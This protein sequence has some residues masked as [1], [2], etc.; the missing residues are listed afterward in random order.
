MRI[1]VFDSGIGGTA[2]AA[3]LRELLPHTEIMTAD[4]SAHVPYGLRSEPE[5]LDLTRSAIQPLLSASCDAIVLACNTA[6]AAAVEQLRREYPHT[7][8]VGLEPMVKPAAA[9]TRTG[10]IMVCATPTTLSS[11]RYLHLVQRW[12]SG[13]EIVEP[14]CSLW[15]QSIERGETALIDLAPLYEQAAEHTVDVVVLAC[16]HYHWLKPG[17]QEL[18]GDRVR[19]LEPSDAV[20]S[21]ILRVTSPGPHRRLPERSASDSGNA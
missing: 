16:T 6:T 2:V 15:A 7:A 14:D 17:L 19:V 12:A 20:A 5:V 18:L 4:D 3:R 8:F 13:V 1:G 10:T 21:Q 9:L 11:A